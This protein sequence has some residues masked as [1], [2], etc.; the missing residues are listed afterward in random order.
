MVSLLSFG[1]LDWAVYDTGIP[2]LVC[3]RTYATLFFLV[4]KTEGKA[5]I[6][7]SLE[8]WLDMGLDLGTVITSLYSR[9]V[10]E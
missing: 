7:F 4:Y 3:A 6:I 8:F 9:I 1:A 2:S 5:D 10:Y